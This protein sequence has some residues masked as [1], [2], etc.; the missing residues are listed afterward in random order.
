MSVH[1][2]RTAMEAEDP[3]GI[4][5]TLA[6]DAVLHSPVFFRGVEGRE[7]IVQALQ[8]VAQ[9]LDDAEFVNEIRDQSTVLLRFKARVGEFDLEGVDLLTLDEDGKVVDLT[10]FMRPYSAAAAFREG[11]LERVASLESG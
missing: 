9:V 2:F 4:A 10:V 11:M 1:P 6:E 8:L 5:A 7:S 3:D